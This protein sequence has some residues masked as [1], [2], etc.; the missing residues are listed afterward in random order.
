[1]SLVFVDDLEWNVFRF[2]LERR[3]LHLSCDCDGLVAFQLQRRLRRVAIDR[4]LFLLDQL[5]HARAAHIAKR[6]GEELIE[7]AAASAAVAVKV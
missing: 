2:R 3:K 1:M 4:D 5:L 7:A 6:G